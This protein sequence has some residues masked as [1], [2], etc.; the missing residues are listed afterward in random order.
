[1]AIVV[2]DAS[3][4]LKWLLPSG[5]AETDGDAAI[6]LLGEVRAHR[7][8]LY[9]P[10]HWLAEVAAVLTRLSPATVMEDVG[11]L[12]AMEIPVLASAAVYLTACEMA[13][14]LNHHLFDTLYHAAALHL[15][16]AVLITADERYYRKARRRGSIERLADFGMG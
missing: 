4:V 16:D 13:S 7:I 15:P 2:A 6:R 3:V 11:D 5:T 14:T 8:R 9:E 10:V 1:M 12:L